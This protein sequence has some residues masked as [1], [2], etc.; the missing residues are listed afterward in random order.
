[1]VAVRQRS[2]AQ[3]EELRWKLSS[4][5]REPH[6]ENDSYEDGICC[7][8]GNGQFSVTLNGTVFTGGSYELPAKTF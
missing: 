1:V 6:L 8:E 5:P 2:F 3:R 4:L 7:Q